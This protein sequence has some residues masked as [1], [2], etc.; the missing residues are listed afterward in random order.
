MRLVC[1]EHNLVLNQHNKSAA[2]ILLHT[3]RRLVMP[4][5]Y[6]LSVALNREELFGQS[7]VPSLQPGN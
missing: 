5:Q 4:A 6:F 2:G 7:I 1:L 3:C